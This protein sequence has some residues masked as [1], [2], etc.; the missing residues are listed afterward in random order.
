M[1]KSGQTRSGKRQILGNANLRLAIKE[2][3]DVLWDQ[4]NLTSKKRTKV[5]K[6]FDNT[7][8][9]VC[10]CVL[11]PMNEEQEQELQRRL[12]SRQGKH[13]PANVI[14]RAR[15]SFQIPSTNEGFN[16]VQFYDIYGNSVD[17]ETA[18]KAF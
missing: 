5:L 16:R 1:M 18:L 9:K 15:N 4:T 8:R 12:K 13:I 6:K 3:K 2:G 17:R 14:S 10:H 11:P 7:Y